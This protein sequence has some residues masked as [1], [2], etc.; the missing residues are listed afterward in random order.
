MSE[1]EKDTKKSRLR[2]LKNPWVN[3]LAVGVGVFLGAKFPEKVT[4]FGPFGHIYLAMLQMCVL[5]IIIS[6][7]IS[8]VCKLFKSSLSQRFVLNVIIVFILGVLM[9]SSIGALIGTVAAPGKN[10]STNTKKALGREFVNTEHSTSKAS[11]Q[12]TESGIWKLLKSIVPANIFFAMS[13]GHS[14][15]VVFFAVIFGAALGLSKS[16]DYEYMVGILDSIYKSFFTILGWALYGLP[17]GLICLLS[18]QVAI[19]GIDIII[20]LAKLITAFTIG[21]LILC[22]IYTF[23]ISFA[24]KSSIVSVLSNLKEALV[25]S[26]VVSSSIPAIPIALQ[27][28]QNDLKVPGEICSFTVPLAV[29]INRQ[30]YTMLFSLTAVF[31]AQLYDVELTWLNIVL[32][33]MASS[34]AGMAAIGAPAVIAPMISYV[35]YPLGLPAMVGIAVFIAISPAI[36]HVLSMTNLFASCASTSLISKNSAIKSAE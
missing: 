23:T 22:I 8:S 5:P 14:L 30:A 31:V 3:L 9:S 32:L 28:M 1:H 26:F 12:K 18:E 29:V 6:A 35:F 36:D 24:T 15:A 19:A 13:M 10:L 25:V 16:S 7:I 27:S 4:I 20:N 2:Y 21:C 33:I 17:F 11:D 34:L